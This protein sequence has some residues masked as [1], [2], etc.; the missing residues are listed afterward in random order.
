VSFCDDITDY[1]IIK[2]KIIVEGYDTTFS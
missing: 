1:R 2:I